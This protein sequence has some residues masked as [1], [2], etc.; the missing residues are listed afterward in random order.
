MRRSNGTWHWTS[1]D[2]NVYLW[3]RATGKTVWFCQELLTPTYI[4]KH[5]LTH[6]QTRMLVP[7]IHL[8]WFKPCPLEGVGRGG[9]RGEDSTT[10]RMR[11][12]GL[13]AITPT[14][15]THTCT[16]ADAESS[17]RFTYSTVQKFYI[18]L[19]CLDSHLSHIN[20]ISTCLLLIRQHLW[21]DDTGVLQQMVW[22][23][24]YSLH[25]SVQDYMR[26]R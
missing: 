18:H 10:E 26:I 16:S 13:F 2:W 17:L 12:T 23:P 1:Q 7:Q 9:W 4:R 20:T 5:T 3:Q 22:P 21:H 6:T 8:R 11:K 25:E 19:M 14:Q 24:Q 15:G